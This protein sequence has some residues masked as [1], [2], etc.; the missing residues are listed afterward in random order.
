MRIAVA[1]ATGRAGRHVVD[2]LHEQGHEAIAISRAT[3]VDVITGEGL[4]EALAGVDAIIDVATGPSPEQQA[5][6]DFFTTAARNLQ[7]AD[8]KLIVAASIIGIDRMSGGYSLAKAAHE[9]ALREGPIPVRILRASQFHEFVEQLTQ[10]GTRGDTAFVPN[11]RTQLVAARAVAERLVELA[12]GDGPALSEIAGPREERL[13]E[14]ATLVAARRGAPA[15][16]VEGTDPGDPDGAL[17]A[18]GV[19]LPGPGALLAGPTF[20]QWLHDQ[21]EAGV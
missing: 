6:T 17:I 15:H 5:A 21:V 20:E 18:E 13:A 11:M 16:V 14:A 12:T 4:A 9:R 1:G 7:R 8:A 3:G 10:W 19:L 2:V